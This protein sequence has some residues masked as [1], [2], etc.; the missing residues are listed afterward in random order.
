MIISS[1]LFLAI[2]GIAVWAFVRWVS[3]NTQ[4]STSHPSTTG[5]EGPSA[6]EILRRRYARGEIDAQTFE[7]MQAQLDASSAYEPRQEMLIG[8]SRAP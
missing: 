3:A 4:A 1:V 7:R 8:D 6:H 5:Y 2:V